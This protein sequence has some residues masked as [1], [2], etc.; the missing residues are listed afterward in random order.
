MRL[1]GLRLALGLTLA[2]LLG[3]GVGLL[4]SQDKRETRLP[5]EARILLPPVEP[6]PERSQIGPPAAAM[7]LP[8]P[9]PPVV[10]APGARPMWQRNAVPVVVPP[11]HAMVAIVIDDMRVDRVRSERAAALPGPLTLAYLPYARAV[12]AQIAAAHA[13]GHEILLHMP[14]EPM[15][16]EDPGPSAL[17]V[18]LDRAEIH[19]RLSAALAVAGPAVGLNNHMGSRFTGDRAAM[20]AVMEALEARGLGFL[21][22]LTTGASAG[23]ALAREMQVPYAVRDVFLDND[24]AAPAVRERLAEAE[25]LARRRGY[26]VA[27]GHPHDGTLA[28]LAAWLREARDRG[29]VPVPISAVFR[30]QQERAALAARPG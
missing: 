22:S 5:A 30:L 14:M 3:A 28:A 13:R 25:A 16:A 2:L 19:R 11:G 10:P 17:G 18:A 9:P 1:S 12:E 7:V 26:A 24:Q 27:I 29:I 23:A 4:A 15:G 8:A 20:R 21:D 6:P